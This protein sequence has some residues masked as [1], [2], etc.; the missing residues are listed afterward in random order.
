MNIYGTD[1]YEKV[2]DSQSSTG[3][4]A[5]STNRGA[6]QTIRFFG[7]KSHLMKIC[8]T[9]SACLVIGLLAPMAYATEKPQR[10]ERRVTDS[11]KGGAAAREPADIASKMLSEF[12]TDEDGMLNL[13]ELTA[14]FEGMRDRLQQARHGQSRAGQGKSKADRR[15]LGAGSGRQQP[16]KGRPNGPKSAGA[17]PDGSNKLQGRPAPKSPKQRARGQNAD[18]AQGQRPGGVRP[19]PNA[20]Q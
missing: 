14:M 4:A 16:L 7:T 3:H 19:E 20:A 9:A 13:R 11:K 1:I 15:G 10:A 6:G 18:P 5:R 12:D 8:K 17:S 2:D